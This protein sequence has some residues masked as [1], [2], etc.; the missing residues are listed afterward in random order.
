MVGDM[1]TRSSSGTWRH[2]GRE[3]P[4]GEAGSAAHPGRDFTAGV[5]VTPPCVAGTSVARALPTMRTR[6]LIG[7]GCCSLVACGGTT[8]TSAESDR[9]AASMADG[10]TQDAGDTS[11]DATSTSDAGPTAPD[12]GA[13]PKSFA[14]LKGCQTD[15]D[16]IALSIPTC[17]GMRQVVGIAKASGPVFAACNPMPSCGNLGCASSSYVTPE[18]G[19]AV[20]CGY[21]GFAGCVNVACVQ[22]A[23]TSEAPPSD[24]GGE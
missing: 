19:A 24:A 3:T 20:D 23:C 21:V 6:F 8:A 15:S 18:Q 17:C 22:G 1:T 16:C 4:H 10:F 5:S 9:D 13:C 7:F 14:P 11:P 12:G 2:G